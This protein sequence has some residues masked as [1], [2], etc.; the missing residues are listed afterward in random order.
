MRRMPWPVYL[1]PGLPQISRQGSW[2]ALAAA[3]IAALVLNAM[4]LG[5][6]VWPDLIG[7]DFRIICWMT[8][9]VAWSAAAGASFWWDYRE[10]GR[11]ADP[12][13]DPLREAI[14]FYLRGD[15]F[16][17]E[18]V[19]NRL[20]R[21]N[22]RDLESRLM[23]ATLLRHTK[24]FDDATR[25][26]NILARQEGAQQWE[27]EIR[28]EGELITEARKRIITDANLAKANSGEDQ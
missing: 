3:L 20:L 19:L 8:L 1:W 2:T 16:E 22:G 23:L 17:T 24:R 15:W 12:N 26:L 27:L 9:A 6:F 25:Q 11:T 21:R 18:R 28:R 5:S 7:P 13:S 14:D 4:L 10:Q